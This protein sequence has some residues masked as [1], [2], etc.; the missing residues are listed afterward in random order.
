VVRGPYGLHEGIFWLTVHPLLILSLIVAL[1]LNWKAESR[2]KLILI[3]FAIYFVV[4]VVTQIYF[5]P[6]L[7]AF[8]RSPESNVSPSEWIARGKRWQRLSWIRGAVMYA[9]ILPLLFALTKPVSIQKK[10]E[11]S[12]DQARRAESE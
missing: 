6:E 8:E 7:L 11:L 4:L 1:V 5:L 3:T 12:V 2:R 9:A 10:S